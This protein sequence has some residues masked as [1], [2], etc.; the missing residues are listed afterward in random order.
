MSVMGIKKSPKNIIN[1][2]GYLY[3]KL[4]EQVALVCEEL[5]FIS[6]MLKCKLIQC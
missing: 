5:L 2:R 4:T 1:F 3:L 6:L